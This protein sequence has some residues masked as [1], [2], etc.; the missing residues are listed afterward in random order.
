VHRVGRNL[1]RILIPAVGLPFAGCAL[2]H[3]YDKCGLAGCA[4]DTEIR[5][6]VEQQFD[7]YTVL[8]PP[9]LIRVQAYNHVVYLTGW[10]NSTL[11]I[12]LA[13]DV[14]T[15]VAGKGNV[16]NSIVLEYQGR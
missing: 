3:T 8:Q 2:V 11:T 10:V 1:I 4:G 16:V 15:D 6:R 7:H 13:G 9:N 5:A 14:A 12:D